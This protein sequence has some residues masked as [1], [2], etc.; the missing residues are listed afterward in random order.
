MDDDALVRVKTLDG[1][2]ILVALAAAKKIQELRDLLV[3][4]KWPM[5]DDGAA[6]QRFHLIHK[7]VNL[8]PSTPI[9]SLLLQDEDFI[10]CVP[11][12]RTK[13]SSDAPAE[14]VSSS[15]SVAVPPDSSK[16]RKQY[17]NPGESS[18]EYPPSLQRME[19][20]FNALNSVC[21]FLEKNR[22]ELTWASVKSALQHSCTNIDEV[23]TLADIKDLAFIC[24]KVIV[25]KCMTGDESQDVSITMEIFP[26][27][28]HGKRNMSD[29]ALTQLTQ[30]R[31]AAFDYAV[32]D[33]ISNIRV[34]V[35]SPDDVNLLAMQAKTGVESDVTL[36]QMRSYAKELRVPGGV[37][38]TGPLL[39]ARTVP[40]RANSGSSSNRRQEHCKDVKTLSASEMVEHLKEVL[41]TSGQIIH[42][43][44]LKCRHAEFGMLQGE[45]SNATKTALKN[46]GV[47]RL[48]THQA[49]AV[50]AALMSKS[51][52][53]ST[54]TASG[55]SL[56]YN[57][58]V[59]E[60]M[61]SS[62]ET[63]ALYLFPTK[64]LAQDQ[65][66]ALLAF[67]NDIT[68]GVYDGDTSQA[69]RQTLREK[70]RILI[71]NPDM[72]HCS[73]LPFH[74]QF[75]RFLSNLRHLV[76]DEAHAYRG[77]FGC[78]V[79]L[80]LRRLRRICAHL[81]GTVPTFIVCSATVANP[82]EHTM[83]LT[84]LREVTSIAEDGSPCGEKLFLLWN[85]PVRGIKDPG[86][87]K[88][89]KR[90]S[91]I[92]EVAYLFAEMV[93]HGLRCI[94]FCKTRKLCELVLAYTHGVLKETAPDLVHTIQ[95]YRAGYTPEE[96]R[97]IEKDLFGGKLRGVAATSALEL[98][99]DVGS[100]DATLH[101]GF[102]GT[103]ASLWQQA[104][105]AGRR[106]KTSLSIYVA[107]EG[108]LD[109]HFFK[110]PLRLFS[111]PI[112]NAQIDS[113]NPQVL[114]QHLTCAAFE[115]HLHSVYDED[116]FSTSL[117]GA[118]SELVRKGCVARHPSCSIVN[119]WTYIGE[120]KLPSATFSIRAIDPDK[121]SIVDEVTSKVI[122]EVEA[123]RA[124]FQIY[125][126]AVY[127]N[128]GKK[129]L[130]NR[131]NLTERLAFC[132][133]TDVK[134]YTKTRDYTDVHV[135][136]SELTYPKRASDVKYR[137]TSAQVNRCQITTSWI[138]FRKIWEV[139][140]ETFDSVDLHLPNVSY[141][142]QAAWIRVPNEVKE[143]VE[144][145]CLDLRAG[146][147]SACHALLNVLPL[148]IMC[149]PSDVG[150]DCAHPQDKR[151]YPV[152]LL[153]FDRCPGGIGISAQAQP[154][155]AEL[156][157]AALEQVLSC[158]CTGNTGCPNC[159]Q[160]FSCDE[161]NEV[162]DKTAAI[163]IL[164]GVIKAEDAL[165]E[166]ATNTSCP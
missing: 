22:I 133:P 106:E 29:S 84:G 55:K 86:D 149:N 67:S 118:I 64:A 13:I 7:G 103:V 27:S 51:I 128:Q 119:S 32:N 123:N 56:C 57:V 71:T 87:D 164:Q 10:A 95:A 131:L 36:E 153:V 40:W 65:L 117:D 115:H 96:R 19:R 142:S 157:Q 38:R 61:L 120:A 46:I 3:A 31:K 12:A 158:D 140:N 144:A 37:L 99:I 16:R 48:Y 8:S 100:L 162:L 161:Y 59:L 4:R 77:A 108:P 155:F 81:Y 89:A 151:Y 137:L 28:C 121:Y 160:Y 114:G 63:C 97:R 113:H 17:T 141:D 2:S 156:L 39:Y 60:S 94:T 109:Q 11:H 24:P 146:L 62:T 152:R 34:W 135:V 150:T 76:I 18:S 83:E 33:I 68:A 154:L 126:G 82:R 88:P 69:E 79:A 1:Q 116:Y 45:L 145:K 66:R 90:F 72:L 42:C 85:P 129:F 58:P 14:N 92:L 9:S 25:V 124:F 70:A 26:K 74:K 101:L 132:R 166:E 163:L 147:H 134:Y 104:G 98:G 130:V 107:F 78:H 111:R 102:P 127:I 80:I 148:Y 44:R 41:G 47:A 165:R 75:A 159:V 50:D 138:G 49:L 30:R 112:E 143:A 35:S 122:E 23:V 136:G 52:V 5:L 125:E 139:S 110:E 54:S 6:A 93:Q 73:I 20:V 21:G 53:V 43:E 105:R 15:A 91:P